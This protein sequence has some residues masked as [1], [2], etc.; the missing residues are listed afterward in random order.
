MDR[1]ALYAIVL[2]TLLIITYQIVFVKPPENLPLDEGM[3]QKGASRP[4]AGVPRPDAGATISP[5][6][7]PGG[8]PVLGAIP[9]VGLEEEPVEWAT[10]PVETPLYAL[11][12]DT[13][14]ATI[15]DLR[16]VEFEGEE[17]G[18]VVLVPNEGPGGLG[19]IL[20]VRDGEIDLRGTV[21]RAD[22]DRVRL[23]GP[24]GPDAESRVTLERT[25]ANGLTVKR[26]FKFRADS[27]RIDVDQVISRGPSAPEVYSY[28]LLWEPGIAFTEGDPENEKREMGAVTFTA[29]KAI[30]DKAG[31]VKEG[32]PVERTGA[33][34]A[35][36]KNKYFAIALA[37]DERAD[38]DV[39]I[40]RMG[41]EE[42]VFLDMRIAMPDP[43]RNETGIGIYAVPL[44]MDLLKGEGIGLEGLIDLGWVY[45]RPISGL[46]LTAINFLY[47]YVP[48]YG[49]VIILIS[50]I[51][52]ILFYRLT[53]KSFKSM[54][55]MQKIQGQVSALKEKYK[56][57]AQR[58]NKETMA[59]YKR[60]GV[61]PLG[62][63]LP[64]LLQMPVF[65]ALYQ[66]LQRTIGLRRAPFMLWMDDLSRPDVL[67]N[68][69]FAL[70][71]LGTHLSLL[72]LL[73]GASMILQQKMTTVDPRQKAL[74]YMMPVFMTVL[75]YRLPSGLVLYWFVNNVLS[76]GQQY[77]IHRGDG[78]GDEPATDAKTTRQSGKSTK[79][80]GRGRSGASPAKETS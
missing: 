51:T 9:E 77:L 26:I 37:P 74:V 75:F 27:Y 10:I 60:E 65:I 1:K 55:D 12:I 32:E 78:K 24:E 29:G 52:K 63:C 47:K 44:E 6:P 54:K 57:D 13:R 20:K 30:T 68:L 61:N 35:A 79:G 14:G 46:T 59:L 66:V 25:L 3:V 34:W 33:R 4:E 42:R 5:T 21:F 31:K 64:M 19:L 73:M 67:T 41:E 49:V 7:P 2:S 15:R 17:D 43:V 16:L 70:P 71:F 38:A 62:G 48:N 56:G 28:R 50:L 36:V 8:E 23:R 40:H 72:P 53:H 76:I 39:M 11:T 69:P 22:R 18:P 58:L 45:I 80:R